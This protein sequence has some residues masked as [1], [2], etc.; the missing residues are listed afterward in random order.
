MVLFLHITTHIEGR[1]DDDLLKKVEGGGWPHLVAMD[2]QGKVY[3]SPPGRK[4]QQFRDYMK[5]VGEY[6]QLK[7]KAEKG[8]ANAKVEFFIRALQLGDYKDLQSAEKH[9]K[10]LSK[11]GKEQKA[12]IE[13]LFIDLEVQDVLKPVMEN[14]DRSKTQEL[15]AE[16]GKTFAAMHK[17]GRVPTSDVA[18]WRFYICM[19]SF[20][21]KEKDIALF[22]E[23]LAKVEERFGNDAKRYADGRRQVLEKLKAEKEEK[24]D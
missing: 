17:K 4:V 5:I 24:K 18:F 16:A 19:N 11:V 13:E 9:L 21:E 2:A 3:G 22:E 6:L 14:R 12:K 10:T 8:D 1:K 7:P 23:S 20:A 15:Q